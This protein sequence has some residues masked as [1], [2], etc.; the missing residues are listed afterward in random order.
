M[1]RPK[2]KTDDEVL[3]AATLV[4]KRYGPIDFTLSEVS[5]AVGLSRA[6]LI[7]RFTNRDT[8]LVKMMERSLA[9][10]RSHLDAMPKHPGSKGLWLFLQ[11]LVRSMNTNYDFSVNFLISWYEVQI[12]ELHALAIQRNRS[13][14]DAIRGR[15]PADAPMHAE[16]LIHAVIAGATTQ[17]AS[18]QRGELADYVLVQLAALLHLM[19][20]NQDD[21]RILAAP[22]S[23]AM[24]PVTISGASR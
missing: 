10:V 14:V 9:Q 2:L 7:Q 17:W 18:E 4:L 15:L 20:P 5:N 13:V 8:L 16:V 11:T 3:D 1:P 19:F 24:S 21:F 12:P 23:G 22:S 6:T